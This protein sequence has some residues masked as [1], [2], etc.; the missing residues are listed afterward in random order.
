MSAM[1]LKIPALALL[2]V[3][4][5]AVQADEVRWPQT[6]ESAD[7]IPI[8]FEVIGNGGEPALVFIHGWSC[9]G[10]Y[11]REQVA[12]FAGKHQVVVIDLAGHGHSGLGRERYSVA[13]F[14]QDVRAVVD[15]VGAE[16][17][18]LV[19]HSMGGPVAVAATQAMPERVIGIVGVDTFQDIGG[20]ISQE[21]FDALVAPMRA[22]FR[23]GAAAFVSQMLVEETDR[24]L[25]EWIVADMSAAP[26]EV[27]VSA[28]EEMLTDTL[29]G[30]SRLAF[31]GLDIPIVAI[32]ADL[33][34][35]NTEGNRRHIGSFEAVIL[36]GTDHFL[37]MGEPESFNRELE[38]V[39]ASMVKQPR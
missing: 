3:L 29:S 21:E 26:P 22:D 36:E 25:R 4:A 39:I 23:Q 18:I 2:L 19:G 27:A 14:G 13:A 17:V 7:G 30:R 31:D 35:T 37:Q 10:R 34:P 12:H 38:R 24:G 6:V 9:D 8:A 1:R 28:M 33:W 15:A 20:T 32:N 5:W 11:W 16:Q